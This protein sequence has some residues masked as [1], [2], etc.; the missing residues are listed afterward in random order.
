MQCS[1]AA[2]IARDTYKLRQS[3]NLANTK[4]RSQPDQ[5]GLQ[6]EDLSTLL[7]AM[8]LSSNTQLPF[9]TYHSQTECVMASR[10]I[11]MSQSSRSLRPNKFAALAVAQYS[12]DLP[13]HFTEFLR[14]RSVCIPHPR[15]GVK[16]PPQLITTYAKPNTAASTSTKNLRVLQLVAYYTSPSRC[17]SICMTLQRTARCDG[18]CYACLV[19][20][21]HTTTC[22]SQ[23][24][25]S[26]LDP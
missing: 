4:S 15:K 6:R 21:A 2:C 11:H 24:H 5:R 18:S 25:A 17:G 1:A 14:T 20:A 9:S 8:P 7:S 16:Q 10:C 23:Q 19:A 13:K 26:F 12:Q 22:L 3:P